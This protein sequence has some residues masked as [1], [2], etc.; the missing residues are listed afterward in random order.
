MR[1]HGAVYQL[2]PLVGELH[3]HAARVL[4]VGQ[5]LHQAARLQA[6]HAV[7]HGARGDHER[8]EQGR[9]REAEGRARAAQRGQHVEFPHGHAEAGK[10]LFQP[11]LQQG[12]AALDAAYGA[13]GAGVQVGAFAR[14]LFEDG[15]YPVGQA[16]EG[17]FR[18]LS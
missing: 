10:A 2:Q 8:G 7:G 9:G 13:H 16:G 3:Q 5:A 15:V 11:L 4:R 1:F 12:G 14:P 17:G 6:F 18:H